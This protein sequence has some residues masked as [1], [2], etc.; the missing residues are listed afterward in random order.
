VLVLNPGPDYLRLGIGELT[1][2]DCFYMAGNARIK[3]LREFAAE[4]LRLKGVP[5]ELAY[6]EGAGNGRFRIVYHTS[7]HRGYG[8]NTQ[9]MKLTEDD[10][11]ELERFMG[12][13]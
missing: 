11:K 6:R 13:K 8:T 12:P 7:K 3:T 5:P 1:E 10:I 9:H 2:G 4:I